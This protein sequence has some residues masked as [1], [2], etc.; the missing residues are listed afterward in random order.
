MP[1]DQATPRRDI[2][3]RSEAGAVPPAVRA[4]RAETGGESID[5]GS[6]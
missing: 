5:D 1:D 6:P 4:N 3:R 2:C